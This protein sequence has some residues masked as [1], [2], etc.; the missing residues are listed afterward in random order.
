M[1]LMVIPLWKMKINWLSHCLKPPTSTCQPCQPRP[2]FRFGKVPASAPSTTFSGFTPTPGAWYLRGKRS[3]NFY[4]LSSGKLTKSYGK[5]W[6][7]VDLPSYKMV[8]CHSY[9]NVY[10]RV[11]ISNVTMV[12]A[13]LW[14]WGGPTLAN[15]LVTGVITPYIPIIIHVLTS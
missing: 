8:I 15:W 12:Y 13:C 14:H 4:R 1:Y 10:Q 11:T 7:T 3:P 9:V 6:F 2:L 5:W